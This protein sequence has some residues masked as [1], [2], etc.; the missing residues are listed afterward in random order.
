MGYCKYQKTTSRITSLRSA[1]GSALLGMLV[2]KY[3]AVVQCS[4]TELL[5]GN[6]E[7]RNSLHSLPREYDCDTGLNVKD[8]WIKLPRDR[9]GF[10]GKERYAELA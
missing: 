1:L 9:T 5:Q 10:E 6:I 2:P 3:G 8:W 4:D 7:F